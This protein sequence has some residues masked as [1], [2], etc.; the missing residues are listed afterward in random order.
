LQITRWTQLA[1]RRLINVGGVPTSKGMIAEEIPKYLQA[2]VDK[3]NELK[4]FGDEIKANH[5]LLNEYERGQGILSHFDGPMFYPTISTISIGSHAVLEFNKPQNAHDEDSYKIIKEFKLLVA[6]RS[7]L[8]LK[9]DLYTNYMHSISEIKEDDLTDPLLRNV[10]E[11]VRE[12]SVLERGT[13]YSL[14]I[15]N[16]PKTSKLKLKF[17]K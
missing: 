6:P 10:D 8:I 11:S 17:F 3:I 13:R 9:D 2:Y 12:A 14:T 1:H 15:R 4:I 5:I 7:L 16:V